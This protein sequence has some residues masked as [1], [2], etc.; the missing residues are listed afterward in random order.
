MSSVVED[1]MITPILEPTRK[2]LQ[3]ALQNNIHLLPM[4][5]KYYDFGFNTKCLLERQ[6]MKKLRFAMIIATI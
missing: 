5:E 2:I 4:L 1:G 3:P 6:N